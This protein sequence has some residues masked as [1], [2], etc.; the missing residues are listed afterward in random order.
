MASLQFVIDSICS[1]L[2]PESMYRIINLR[3]GQGPFRVA[4]IIP[5]VQQEDRSLDHDSARMLT[6][7]ALE[8]LAERGDILVDG[9]SVF[10]PRRESNAER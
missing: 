4:E 7:A 8:A 2:T 1:K 6:D 9:G 5:M 3:L 10:S